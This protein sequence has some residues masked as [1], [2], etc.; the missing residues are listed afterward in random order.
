MHISSA[1]KIV[2][3]IIIIIIIIIMSVK[4]AGIWILAVAI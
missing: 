2:I 3:I 1:G 4:K